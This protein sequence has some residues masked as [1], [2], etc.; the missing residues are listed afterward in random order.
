[1][2]TQP[3]PVEFSHPQSRELTL[4]GQEVKGEDPAG[5]YF[6]SPAEHFSASSIFTCVS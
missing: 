1:M 2:T 6:N 3:P 4:E 5:D